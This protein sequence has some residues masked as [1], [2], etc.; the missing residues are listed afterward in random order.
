MAKFRVF[1]GGAFGVSRQACLLAVDDEPAFGQADRGTG[2]AGGADRRIEVV[3]PDVDGLA[4]AGTVQTH[5]RE[6]LAEFSDPRKEPF[7]YVSL[8]L[9]GRVA[10]DLALLAREPLGTLHADVLVVGDAQHM[11]AAE[12]V[13]GLVARRAG[14]WRPADRGVVGRCG[15]DS[16]TP[17]GAQSYQR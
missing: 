14:T 11:S 4:D 8:H 5:A 13:G 17:C 6:V 9:P 3:D 1:A 16:E 12:G 10:N 2:S 15:P 7:E